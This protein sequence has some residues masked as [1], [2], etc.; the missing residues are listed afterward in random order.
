M[1][2]IHTRE[3]LESEIYKIIH[4]EI[5][6]WSEPDEDEDDAIKATKRICDLIADLGN[7]CFHSNDSSS[8]SSSST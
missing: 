4:D 7:H 6:M 5:I 8:S 3:Q 2:Q 1:K